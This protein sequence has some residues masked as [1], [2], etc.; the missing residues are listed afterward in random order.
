M[1][2]PTDDELEAMA[3]DM[4]FFQPGE[5]SDQAAAMLR[6]CKSG[7]ETEALHVD[8]SDFALKQLKLDAAAIRKKGP[9]MTDQDLTAPEAVERLANRIGGTPLYEGSGEE[10]DL[11]DDA[12]AALRAL[13]AELEDEREKTSDGSFYQEKD[14][15]A[16]VARAEAAEA[17]L[18]EAVGA[19]RDLYQCDE[20][21]VFSMDEVKDRARA[22]IATLDQSGGSQE[23]GRAPAPQKSQATCAFLLQSPGCLYIFNS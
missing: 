22:F 23:H 15:D 9:P 14:I 17:K 12:D 5:T 2:H 6:A 16:L 11:P 7:D 21:G 4:M 1:T 8:L 20:W 13:S 19:M 10:S 18:K 3:V